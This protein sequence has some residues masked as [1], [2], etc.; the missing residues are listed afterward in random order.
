MQNYRLAW[1]TKDGERKTS[2]VAFSESAATTY[3][4]FYADRLGPKTEIEIVP[5]KP[6][7]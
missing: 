1:T 3:R 6:G 2:A 5:V 7:E 4:G